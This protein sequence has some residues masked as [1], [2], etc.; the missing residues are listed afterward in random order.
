MGQ[1]ISGDPRF[2]REEED[3]LDRRRVQISSTNVNTDQPFQFIAFYIGRALLYR[4]IKHL[5]SN[6]CLFRQTKQTKWRQI[7]GLQ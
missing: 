1:E 6:L 3:R 4:Q 2:H 5:W 7:E